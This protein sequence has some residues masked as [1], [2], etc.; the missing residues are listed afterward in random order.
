MENPIVPISSTPPALR[1]VSQRRAN[2]DHAEWIGGRVVTL[3]LHEFDKPMKPYE[4]AAV[5]LDWIEVLP[6]FD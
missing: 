1:L 4:L 5:P 6:P 3:L 2:P